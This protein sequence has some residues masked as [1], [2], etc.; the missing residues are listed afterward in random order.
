MRYNRKY[1]QY[2]FGYHALRHLQFLRRR[3]GAMT[4]LNFTIGPRSLQALLTESVNTV[5]SG[6]R[7][8]SE[9]LRLAPMVV[10][11]CSP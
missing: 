3:G 5:L 11:A 1:L 9:W 10:E 8:R 6:K 7:P 4:P 2:K